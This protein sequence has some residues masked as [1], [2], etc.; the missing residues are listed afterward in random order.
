MQ[1]QLE[2]VIFCTFLQGLNLGVYGTPVSILPIY[3]PTT[4][5]TCVNDYKSLTN[6]NLILDLALPHPPNMAK[7]SEQNLSTLETHLK[8]I[9]HRGAPQNEV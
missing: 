1:F 3:Y 8:S 5:N 4:T 9:S 2:S 6:G 7:I